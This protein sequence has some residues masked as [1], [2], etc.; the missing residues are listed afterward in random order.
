MREGSWDEAYNLAQS[1][2]TQLPTETVSI[3]DAVGRTLAHDALSLCNLPAYETSSMDGWAISGASPWKIIGEVATGKKSSVQLSGG[4]ALAIAT[5]GVIPDGT[6]AV[7]P[8][9]RAT[10]SDGSVSGEIEEGA[11]IRPAA[12]ECAQG[13][14]LAAAGTLLTPPMVGLL[15]ATGHDAL[16]VTQSPRVAIFFLGDE[17]LHSGV[18]VDGSIRDAL[19]PQLPAILKRAGA[20]VIAAEFVKDDLD[21]LNQKI[22]AVLDSADIIVTTGGTADGPRDYVKPAIAHL[23][24]EKVID[25]ARVRPGYHVL[26]ARISSNKAFLALPGNPQSA[27]AAFTSFGAPLIRSLLGGTEPGIKRIELSQ[28]LKTPENFSRLVPGKLDGNTF[29]QAGYLG[30]AMLRGVAASE[31]FA[32]I[33]PG[34]NPSGAPARWLPLL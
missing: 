12:M 26:I 32:L 24:G 10:E 6:T 18:P 16:E 21:T 30:S 14:L 27:L 33:E 28:P 5:G 9:E 25:C 7:I 34:D 22:A 3:N 1:A 17:L 29:I 8:W 19:G 2:F 31:G 20:T 11:N 23:G 15:A 4:Q 13:D